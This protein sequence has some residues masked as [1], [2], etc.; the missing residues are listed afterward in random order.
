MGSQ[1]YDSSP[2]ATRIASTSLEPRL[3]ECPRSSSWQLVKPGRYYSDGVR[4]RELARRSSASLAGVRE[5]L[6]R[7]M[8]AW[9]VLAG[10]VSSCAGTKES[11]VPT[12]AEHELTASEIDGDPLA[13]LPGGVVGFARIETP[14]AFRTAFGPSL[15]NLARQLA[16]LPQT[17]GFEVERDL[18]RVF[19]GIYSIQ[20]VDLA[21][22]AVGRFDE[23]KIRAAAQSAGAPTVGATLVQ[24]PYANRT[25]YTINNTGFCILTSHTALFGS[26]TGI[27]RA[28][29]RIREGRAVRRLPTWTDDLLEAKQAP[30]G[31]GV[32]LRANALSDGVRQQL[33]FVEGLEAARARGNFAA[34]GLNLAAS[35]RYASAEQA[36]IGAQRV[37]QARDML[38]QASFLISLFGIAQPIERLEARPNASEVDVVL[39][40]NGATLGRLITQATPMITATA[41]SGALSNPI[42]K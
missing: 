4:R 34:P 5:C 18:D 22:V 28:L 29:D 41:K 36:A 40:G 12:V 8:A 11:I 15:A 20:G 35:L 37:I 32:D 16:P 25:L 26:E 6:C 33:P 9:L 19:V 17:A 14:E 7:S 27:R 30:I 42:V 21:G 1:L 31:M 2:V 23:A 39:S 24:S 10:S 38:S 13:L 3:G